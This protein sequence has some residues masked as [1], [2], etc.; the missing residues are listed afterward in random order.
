MTVVVVALSVALA[1]IILLTMFTCVFCRRK[2]VPKGDPEKKSR[3]S[4][5][6]ADDDSFRSIREAKV[7]QRK[8]SRAAS[9]WRDNIRFAARRRRT[10]RTHAPTA[11]YATLSMEERPEAVI[12]SEGFPP[13]SRS[14]SPT[15][16]QRT[17]PYSP[18]ASA[19]SIHSSTLQ[20]QVPRVSTPPINPTDSLPSSPVISS[21]PPAYYTQPSFLSPPD[22][23]PEYTCLGGGSSSSSKAPLSSH[24]PYQTRSD[25]DSYLNSLS[26]H[27]ATDDKA[28]LSHRAALA[29]APPGGN[30]YLSQ[31]A[32]VPSL[33]DPD[34][35]ELPSGSRPSSPNIDTHGYE[36]QPPYSPPTSLLPPP[37]SKGKQ[38]YDYSRDLD[39][40][41]NFDIV[42][43]EPDLG[44]SAPPFEEHGAVPTAPPFESDVLVPSAPPMPLEDFPD[45]IG[46]TED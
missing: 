29:S 16:M 41:V 22:A 2:S 46:D 26:G 40:D 35:F 25:G 8:W 44:P 12:E 15:S 3:R 24:T 11:S 36:P 9:R 17:S 42:M 27:V 1:V 23:S 4:P 33:E 38:K 34:M 13:S 7:A 20:V 28:I 31:P 14:P 39:I 30:S 10:N 37:P 43:V 32:S 21:Q 5:D 6:I 18:T 45:T 19:A